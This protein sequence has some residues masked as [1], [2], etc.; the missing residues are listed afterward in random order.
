M[1]TFPVGHKT[2]VVGIEAIAV[3]KDVKQG[4]FVGLQ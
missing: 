4:L 1:V 2:I 3:W